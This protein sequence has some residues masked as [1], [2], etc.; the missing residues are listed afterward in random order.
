MEGRYDLV[1]PAERTYRGSGG[2]AILL[3]RRY[4]LHDQTRAAAGVPTT[5]KADGRSAPDLPM[6][7][8]V[9]CSGRGAVSGTAR[10][11]DCAQAD[12]CFLSAKLNRSVHGLLGFERFQT[13][14]VARIR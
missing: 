6:W 14:P 1:E 13:A 2:R 11:R 10:G 8:K 4:G 7:G 3:H 12:A 9:R 5:R